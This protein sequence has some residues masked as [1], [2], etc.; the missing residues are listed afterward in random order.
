M[1]GHVE[2]EAAGA[3]F[4][5]ACQTFQLRLFYYLQA[6][7]S[8]DTAIHGS[9]VAPSYQVTNKRVEHI[10]ETSGLVHRRQQSQQQPQ[11]QR[12]KLSKSSHVRYTVISCLAQARV[13]ACVIQNFISVTSS[14]P[15]SSACT[16]SCRG[17]RVMR[18]GC[19][20]REDSP[21]Y[22][23]R[24]MGSPGSDR[25]S[26]AQSNRETASHSSRSA[27]WMP[28]QMRRLRHI[29]NQTSERKPVL[30]IKVTYPAPNAQWSRSIALGRL[31]DSAHVNVSPRKRSG[32]K[33]NLSWGGARTC[34]H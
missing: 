15:S 13:R 6:D 32:L 11:Q 26:Y 30:A 8:Y 28:G 14:S 20:L 33:A 23:S 24:D 17:V 4:L 21:S 31:L 10:G 9:R 2:A 18:Y 5:P 25:M 1:V 16:R 19:G 7:R 3:R 27:T 34:Q 12:R 22:P 29:R